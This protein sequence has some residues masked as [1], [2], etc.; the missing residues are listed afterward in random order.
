MPIIHA[1]RTFKD[2]VYVRPKCCNEYLTYSTHLHHVREVYICL[3]CKQQY[4]RVDWFVDENIHH[5]LVPFKPLPKPPGPRNEQIP[6]I[7]W[8]SLLI[9]TT[10]VVTAINLVLWGI[11][12]AL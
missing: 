2:G 10:V 7:K 6:K 4:V 5:S 12:H 1:M 3:Q 11:A 9:S 8:V